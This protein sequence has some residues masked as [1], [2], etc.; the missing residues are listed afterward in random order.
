MGKPLHEQL[1]QARERA[2]LTK[3]ALGKAVGWTDHTNVIRVEKGGDTD[4]SALT[5]W[6]EATGHEVLIVQAGSAESVLGR[7]REANERELR[8][9]AALLDLLV[10]HRD[11]PRAADYLERDIVAL[12][13]R[14]DALR[15][16]TP[17]AG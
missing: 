5:R 13:E 2:G 4:T 16:M 15:G 11:D 3:T 1:K 10:S 7:A 14:L 17:T 9:A 12:R 6:A 8:I